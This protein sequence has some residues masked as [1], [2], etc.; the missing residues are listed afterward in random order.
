MMSLV[1]GT[2]LPWL[3]IAVG[4]W[5]G[6]QLVRQNGRILLRLEAIEK[7]AAAGY[8]VRVMLMPV[9][10]IPGWERAYDALLER[11]LTRVTLDRLTIGG[12]CSYGPALRMTE[13]KLG[14]DNLIS[15]SLTVLEHTPDDGRT[16]YP[17]AMRAGIYRRLL[18]TIRR[19][20]PGLACALCMEDVTL[21]REL[22]L[23]DSNVGRCNCIL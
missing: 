16:R 9:I 14:P 1:F 2:V 8:P 17:R 4:A 7:C 19:L 11:L 10:P 6:Y 12:V 13:A 3:L 15:R 18:A 22:S 20:Q 21:A 5:L 23:G